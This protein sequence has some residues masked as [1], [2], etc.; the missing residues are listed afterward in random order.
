MGEVRSDLVHDLMSAGIRHGRFLRRP[1]KEELTVSC[2][3][4]ALARAGAGKVH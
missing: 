1:N 3:Q 2:G 4:I